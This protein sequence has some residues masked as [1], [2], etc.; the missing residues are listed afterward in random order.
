MKFVLFIFV[1]SLLVFFFFQS[2][3]GISENV[4]SQLQKKHEKIL[5]ELNL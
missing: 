5:Q 4:G 2:L 3:N 1:A